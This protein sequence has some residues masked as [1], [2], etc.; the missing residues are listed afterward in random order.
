MRIYAQ[1]WQRKSRIHWI[2]SKQAYVG[3][4]SVKMQ[5]IMGY[6]LCSLGKVQSVPATP[7]CTDAVSMKN[8]DIKVQG[9]L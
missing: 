8:N 2:E 7:V 1:V 5:N 9:S 4:I 6:S 3:D